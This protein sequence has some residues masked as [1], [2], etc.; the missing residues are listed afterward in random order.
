MIEKTVYSKSAPWYNLL[1][2]KAIPYLDLLESINLILKNAPAALPLLAEQISDRRSVIE[3]GILP[4]GFMVPIMDVLM[5]MRSGKFQDFN[6]LSVSLALACEYSV[7]NIPKLKGRTLVALDCSGSMKEIRAYSEA[8]TCQD[9]ACLIAAALYKSQDSDMVLFG[10]NIGDY[11]PPKSCLVTDLSMDL[12]RRDLG[13]TNYAKIFRMCRQEERLYDRIIILSD[14]DAWAHDEAAEALKLTMK[15]EKMK[16][17]G[18]YVV[19]FSGKSMPYLNL[20]MPEDVTVFS[21]WADSILL[22]IIEAQPH[23]KRTES[24][25]ILG[26]R[27]GRMGGT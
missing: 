15:D 23:E 24:P 26:P 4:F 3:A 11:N 10:A 25:S 5:A 7:E 17:P 14:G 13:S 27:D 6:L 12:A 9:V 20:K 2:D 18:I 8:W 22:K 1:R 19:D 21:P 16:H